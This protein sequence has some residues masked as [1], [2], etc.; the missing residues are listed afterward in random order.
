MTPG[1][2][3]TDERK[4]QPYPYPP[5]QTRAQLPGVRINR[6]RLEGVARSG[7]PTTTEDGRDVD[8]KKEAMADESLDERKDERV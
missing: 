8:G 1:K 2:W 7:S 6:L 5:L 4:S 3:V